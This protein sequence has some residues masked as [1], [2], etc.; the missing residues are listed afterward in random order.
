MLIT[1]SA[2]FP[3]T[4]YEEG[5]V[6]VS[7]SST[8]SAYK[9]INNPSNLFGAIFANWSFIAILGTLSTIGIIGAIAAHTI[10]PFA[11]CMGLALFTGLY[12]SVINI[13][14]SITSHPIVTGIV[15]VV[16]ICIG[17]IITA[18]AVEAMKG[19]AEV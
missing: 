19:R 9:D 6:N 8:F 16:G 12:M 17:V 11:V 1:T 18:D 10:L 13:V 5:A 3:Y 7:S 15:V 2:F 14:Y 4:T